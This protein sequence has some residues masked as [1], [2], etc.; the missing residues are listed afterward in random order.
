[1][2]SFACP[3]V[4]FTVSAAVS[5]NSDAFSAVSEAYVDA[6][7]IADFT[8]P[9]SPS[10]DSTDESCF[11]PDASSL[12]K[13]RKTEGVNALCVFERSTKGVEV[14]MEREEENAACEDAARKAARRMRCLIF[15]QYET[16]IDGCGMEGYVHDCDCVKTGRVM[17]ISRWSGDGRYD[18][19]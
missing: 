6:D 17:W 3:Y 4:S 14:L 10:A 13:R 5:A 8:T 11:S 1:M 19:C 2:T 15:H 7:S 12:L 18:D 9:C 16:S